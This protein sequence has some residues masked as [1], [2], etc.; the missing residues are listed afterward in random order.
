MADSIYVS[1]L[2]K[3]YGSFTAVKGI[4][5]RVKKGEIFGFL[6]PNG[7]GKTTTV[8]ML[9]TIID[10]TSG[11]AKVAGFDISNEKE[12][13]RS[14]IG[15]VFQDPSLDD[16]LTGYE[17]LDF[18]AIIYGIG[19]EERRKRIKEMLEMV[20]LT[21]SAD[22]LVVKY[23]GGMRR[24]LEIARGLL[25]EPEVLFLDEPTVGLDAQTRRHILDYIKALNRK[26]RLSIFI[27]THYIEEADYICDRIAIM[28][29]GKIVA[30]D[31]PQNLKRKLQG[32]AAI[33]RLEN[34]DSSNRLIMA[35]KEE[36][37]VKSTRKDG[38]NLYVYVRE[39]ES[40]LP[41]IM[42][43]AYKAGIKITSVEVHKPSLEDVFI[44]YTGKSIR[45]SEAESNERIRGIM[46]SRM[47]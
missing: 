11:Q 33:V 12:K 18:H 36:K 7:A 32:D 39:A 43:I 9:T 24:R 2:V 8:H 16:R 13:V 15:I 34:E 35:M 1:K 47:R 30:C 42:S 17:N 4:S 21:D 45:D 10:K 44:Y 40:A 31:T 3:K 38:L 20:E 23:S 22:K 26:Y 19:K 29:H 28:D 6:G 41:R 14:A 5:F 46:R 25:N 27:T 37:F